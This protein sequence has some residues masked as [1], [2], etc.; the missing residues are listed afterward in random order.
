MSTADDF[1]RAMAATVAGVGI[2]TTGGVGGR[3]GLTVSSTTSVSAE[4]PMLL[5][6]IN[7]RSPVLAAIRANGVFG[8]S[9]LGADQDDLANRFAGRASAGEPHDF[10][11]ARWL[12]GVTGVPLLEEAAA[13]FECAVDRMVEA[14]SHTIA[15]GAVLYAERGEA[16]PLA[17]TDRAYA[18]PT[19]LPSGVLTE[20]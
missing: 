19:P 3:L 13:R 4:P 18:T 10:A 5:V 11:S 1:I 16:V 14:G 17:Y 15:I 12:A 7:R 9:A 6:C 2:V 20:V 8:V